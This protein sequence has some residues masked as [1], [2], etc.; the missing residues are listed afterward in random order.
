MFKKDFQ[1]GLLKFSTLYPLPTRREL[2]FQQAGLHTLS[3]I[4]GQF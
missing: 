1:V 3:W 4:F 2:I